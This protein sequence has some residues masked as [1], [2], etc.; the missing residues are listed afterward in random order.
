MT[1]A[2]YRDIP[3]KLANLETFTGNSMSAFSYDNGDYNVYSYET[4]IATVRR[5]DDDRYVK[6]VYPT[7]DWGR[8]TGRHLNLCR[9]NLPGVEVEGDAYDEPDEPYPG[10]WV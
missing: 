1:V 6:W 8:T 4:L 10:A 9:A 2:A 5:G 7:N 3:D